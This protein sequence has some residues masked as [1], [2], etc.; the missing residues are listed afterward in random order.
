[1]LRRFLYSVLLLFPGGPLLAQSCTTPAPVDSSAAFW[2]QQL[3]FPRVRA[4]QNRTEA[5]SYLALAGWTAM[6]G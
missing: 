4:A 6:R 5:V 3:R 1:M 2:R